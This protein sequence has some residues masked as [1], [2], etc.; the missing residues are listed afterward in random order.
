MYFNSRN[1]YYFLSSVEISSSFFIAEMVMYALVINILNPI[2][3]KIGF[4]LTMALGILLNSF[5]V[6]CIPPLDIMYQ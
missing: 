3:N 6:L 2:T 5:A 4:K 1:Y